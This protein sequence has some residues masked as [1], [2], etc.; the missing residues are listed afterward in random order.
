MSKPRILVSASMEARSISSAIGCDAQL[1]TLK[2]PGGRQA[3]GEMESAAAARDLA[4]LEV[5][6]RGQVCRQTR[7]LLVAAADPYARGHHPTSHTFKSAEVWDYLN[8]GRL[9]HRRHRRAAHLS[10]QSPRWLRGVCG[11]DVS[12]TGY[13]S[14]PELAS[15]LEQTAGLRAEHQGRFFQC[16]EGQSRGA[17]ALLPSLIRP[18]STRFAYLHGKGFRWI[19]C[20]SPPSTSTASSALLLMK[21]N[22]VGLAGGGQMAGRTGA[23]VRL[24]PGHVDHGTA[25]SPKP[26]SSTHWLKQQGYL[27][28]RLPRPMCSSG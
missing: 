11:P 21:S 3:R 10:T 7:R 12:Q 22:L 27:F 23:A 14:R 26:S 2:A 15:D 4:G 18:S 24:H 16:H 19:F 8:P 1:P 17:E 13:T 25:G 28:T 6:R 9:A 20:T 5:L